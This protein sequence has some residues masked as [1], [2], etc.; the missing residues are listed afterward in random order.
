MKWKIDIINEDTL[1][2][3]FLND[4]GHTDA[5]YVHLFPRVCQSLKTNF[6]DRIMDIVPSYASIMVVFRTDLSDVQ[7]W[8]NRVE[9][10]I[11][12]PALFS[13][14]ESSAPSASAQKVKTVELPVYY[15]QSTGPD[16]QRLANEKK[17]NV[18][19][20]IEQ[21]TQTDYSVYALGFAPGF[22]YLGFVP[23]ALATPR[24]DNPRR[25]V[26]KGSVG[27]A[28][29]QT[30]IYPTDSPGGWNIIGRTPLSMLETSTTG[31]THCHLAVGDKVKFYAV[32]EAEFLRLGGEL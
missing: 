30:G 19:A 32:N 15:A 23:D 11:A 9:A 25:L 18:E 17:I 21:H 10:V 12:N 24:L 27:I 1:M 14:D 8:Q 2:I 6:T 28:D 26:K 13:H 31:E 20:L 29:R 7:Q 5:S 3:Y 22:A 4:Q 16:L